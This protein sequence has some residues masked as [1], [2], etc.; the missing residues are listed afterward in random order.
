MPPMA[1]CEEGELTMTRTVFMRF[2]Y[3]SASAGSPVWMTALW[4]WPWKA[5][6]SAAR[7]K[8]WSSEPARSTVSTGQSFSRVNGSSGPTRSASTRMRDVSSGTLNPACC[9]IHAGLWPTA[10]A[11]TLGSQPLLDALTGNR[12]VSSF[13]FSSAVA[14]WACSVRNSASAAS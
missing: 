6:M 5:T 3:A 9:A 7:S 14:R 4:P 12:Y 1:P 11:F 8:P 2:P 13:R 10:T